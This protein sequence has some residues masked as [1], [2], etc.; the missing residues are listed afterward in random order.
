MYNSIIGSVS[1]SR[2]R[3][4]GRWD[5]QCQPAPG[6]GIIC[7]RICCTRFHTRGKAP[8]NSRDSRID[9]YQHHMQRDRDQAAPY[10]TVREL[11]RSRSHKCTPRPHS[12]CKGKRSMQLTHVRSITRCAAI[13]QSG[14]VGSDDAT[15]PYKHAQTPTWNPFMGDPITGT[16]G[17]HYRVV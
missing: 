2:S 11:Q 9:G 8:M 12:S 7:K 16:F 4:Q 1:S 13:L 14:I 3:R 5:L 17:Y 15:P 10:R 6:H